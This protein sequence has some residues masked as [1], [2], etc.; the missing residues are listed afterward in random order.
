MIKDA[1]S[2]PEVKR[3]IKH[4]RVMQTQALLAFQYTMGSRAGELAG[5]YH[6][7]I[8]KYEL[9]DGRYVVKR[10]KKEYDTYGMEVKSFRK[11]GYG[12]CWQA[13]N[14]KNKKMPLKKAWILKAKEKW[15][16]RI[17]I[18]WVRYRKKMKK[19]FLFPLQERRIRQL[20]DNE[21]KK[22]NPVYSSH[23]LRHSRATH[24]ADISENPYMVKNVLGHARLQTSEQYV[25]IGLKDLQKKLIGKDFSKFFG[26]EI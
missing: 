17:L 2:Y 15:L 21:L 13:K 16:Y 7:K 10:I 24:L 1:I 18:A 14:F 11:T 6:H 5:K 4:C 8:L 23:W 25:H 19:R 9:K 3:I 26:E 20:I 22:Y 12:L